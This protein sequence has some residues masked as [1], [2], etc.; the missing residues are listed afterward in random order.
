MVIFQ[1]TTQISKV[2]QTRKYTVYD[3]IFDNIPAKYTG[4]VP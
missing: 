2:G 4:N 3:R 1:L